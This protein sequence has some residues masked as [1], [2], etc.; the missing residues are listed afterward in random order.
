MIIFSQYLSKFSDSD[1][2]LQWWHCMGGHLWIPKQET[3]RQKIN[4]SKKTPSGHF[5]R[6]SNCSTIIRK[7]DHF[8][9]AT[10]ARDG[11]RNI[12]SSLNLSCFACMLTAVLGKCGR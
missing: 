9:M 1:S 4:V 6:I 7:E 11:Q 12:V 8:Y 3:T 5:F 10:I 2:E